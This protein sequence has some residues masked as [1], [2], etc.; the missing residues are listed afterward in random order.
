MRGG[1]FAK[2]GHI[3]TALETVSLVCEAQGTPLHFVTQVQDITPRK[4]AEE[5]RDRLFTHTTNAMCLCGF[6]GMMKRGNPA[7]E[8]QTGMTDDELLSTPFMELVHPEDHEVVACEVRELAAGNLSDLIEFRLMCKDGS[9]K[10]TEW[11]ATPF[12]D[13]NVFYAIGNDVT[14]RRRAREEL[15]RF[16]THTPNMMAVIG[17][18]GL[19]K[20]VNPAIVSVGEGSS[21]KDYIGKTYLDF[22]HPD[23]REQVVL[24]FGRLLTNQTTE[25]FEF[26]NRIQDGSYKWFSWSAT[27][28][29]DW[30]VIYVTAQDVTQRKQADEALRRSEE[31][32]RVTY[33]IESSYRLDDTPRWVVHLLQSKMG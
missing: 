1:T 19:V 5:E 10:W 6:D 32:L 4:R 13:W 17:F 2:D 7:L 27:P 12:L 11:T 24:A 3:V 31:E 30:G 14:E 15:D 21:D 22:F 25:V 16:F 29:P 18:D 23:D 33:G 26:R 28:F 20:R 9:F 8:T